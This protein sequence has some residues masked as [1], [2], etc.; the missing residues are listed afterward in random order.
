MASGLTLFWIR[1]DSYTV[2]DH[3]GNLRSDGSWI[4]IIGVDDSW[5]IAYLK[6]R[7]LTIF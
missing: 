7:V 6:V 1:L 2:P 3:E 5:M 4:D